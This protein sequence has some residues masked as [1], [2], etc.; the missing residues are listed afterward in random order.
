MQGFVCCCLKVSPSAFHSSLC[1]LD[2]LQFLSL[3]FLPLL[4]CLL[5]LRSGGFAFILCYYLRFS[6]FGCFAFLAFLCGC[7]LLFSFWPFCFSF[8]GCSLLSF[9]WVQPFVFIFWVR[10]LFSHFCAFWWH[11]APLFSICSAF[12]SVFFC[13][14]PQLFG[15]SFSPFSAFFGFFAFLALFCLLISV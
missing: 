4:F 12:A 14:C 15:F 1:I 10:P 8:F 11:C 3:G 13:V 6:L 7:G 5:D 9:F 2:S